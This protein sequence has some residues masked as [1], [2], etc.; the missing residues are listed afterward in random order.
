MIRAAACKI[1]DFRVKDLSTTGISSGHHSGVMP[2]NLCLEFAHFSLQQHQTS[3]IQH[4]PNG[5]FMSIQACFAV[6]SL[7]DL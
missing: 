4:F 1:N 2:S 3:F 5:F 7:S 6:R